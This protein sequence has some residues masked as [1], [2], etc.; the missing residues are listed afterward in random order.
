MVGFDD[1]PAAA[2]A[3][4]PL[5]TVTQ[6]QEEKGRLAAQWLMEEIEDDPPAGLAHAGDPADASSS[7]ASRRRRPGADPSVVDDAR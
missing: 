2:H 4:P 5:T 7:C 6:P 1:S 3:T